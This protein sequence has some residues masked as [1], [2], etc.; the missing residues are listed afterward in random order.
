MLTCTIISSPP[1]PIR[2]LSR[3]VFLLLVLFIVPPNIGTAQTFQELK[4]H[5]ANSLLRIKSLHAHS[6]DSLLIESESLKQ[7]LLIN[8]PRIPQSLTDTVENHFPYGIGVATSQIQ[9]D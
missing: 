7:Y 8:L 6:D 3:N 9:N 5:I 4:N 2:N 1:Q